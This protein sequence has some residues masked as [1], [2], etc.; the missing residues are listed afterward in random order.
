MWKENCTFLFHF[1]TG[2]SLVWL[3]SLLI[4]HYCDIKLHDW[5]HFHFENWIEPYKNDTLSRKIFVTLFHTLERKWEPGRYT[6]RVVA[7][8]LVQ[9]CRSRE[10]SA[11]AD[12]LIRNFVCTTT[13]GKMLGNTD[14]TVD[15]NIDFWAATT[16]TRRHSRLTRKSSQPRSSLM[17][18]TQTQKETRKTIRM[19]TIRSI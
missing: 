9:R 14:N 7:H 1:S 15:G 10:V 19:Q 16:L 3:M 17:E 8:L 11:L 6:L 18:Y 4:V 13:L 2:K 5:K 12:T